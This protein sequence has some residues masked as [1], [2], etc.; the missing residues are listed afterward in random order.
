MEN[1]DKQKFF[2][3]DCHTE[4]VLVH[5]FADEDEIYFSIYTEGTDGKYSD[6]KSKLRA[7][8]KILKTGHP[9]ED[10][11]IFSRSKADEFA[12]YIKQLHD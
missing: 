4:G 7:I 6:W 9:Y 11:F 8:W 3:C 5:K 2:V 12:N 1:K 10:Q